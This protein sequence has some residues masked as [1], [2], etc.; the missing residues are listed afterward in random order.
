[1]TAC[2]H[3]DLQLNTNYGAAVVNTGQIIKL[4]LVT[5]DRETNTSRSRSLN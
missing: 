5:A 3:K 4:T 2:N 1:M